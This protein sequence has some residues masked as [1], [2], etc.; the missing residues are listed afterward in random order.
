MKAYL[1]SFLVPGSKD[2]PDGLVAILAITI[3]VVTWVVKKVV[4]YV[5]Y[6]RYPD[7]KTA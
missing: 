3:A 7:T 5:W 2:L 1:K 4:K 6:R